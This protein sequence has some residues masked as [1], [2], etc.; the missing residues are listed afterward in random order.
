MICELRFAK[1]VVSTLHSLPSRNLQ[2]CG[3]VSRSETVNTTFGSLL[4]LFSGVDGLIR[5][6]TAL[7]SMF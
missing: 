6:E 2:D 1:V 4:M 5:M 3:F 7:L